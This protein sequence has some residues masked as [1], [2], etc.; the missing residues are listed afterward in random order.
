[1]NA[2]DEAA[3]YAD[4]PAKGEA[5]PPKAYHERRQR[6]KVEKAAEEE[7][8]R[9]AILKRLRW[10]APGGRS[11][12]DLER[13]MG[14]TP[15]SV[16]AVLLQ[17]RADDLAHDRDE[18]W[19]LGPSSAARTPEPPAPAEDFTSKLLRS[20][21]GSP[22]RWWTRM[23]LLSESCC[24]GPLAQRALDQLVADGRLQ[25]VNGGVTLPIKPRTSEQA[26]PAPT[27]VGASAPVGG[28]TSSSLDSGATAERDPS[29][30][31]TASPPAA[32]LR[33]Q[34]V[35]GFVPDPDDA[36]TDGE[37][38]VQPD[39]SETSAAAAHPDPGPSDDPR[40]TG[41]EQDGAHE[42]G[43]LTGPPEVREDP[44][45][46]SS[47]AAGVATG[48]GVETPAAP[49]DR[50]RD[51]VVA[52]VQ[53]EPGLTTNQIAAR[54]NL[55]R[56]QVGHM[57]ERAGLRSERERDPHAAGGRGVTVAR[58]YWAGSSAESGAAAPSRL[59][60]GPA[61]GHPRRDQLVRLVCEH[62]EGVSVR[63]LARETGLAGTLVSSTLQSAAALG[64]IRRTGATLSSRYWPPVLGPSTEADESWGSW[65]RRR[66]DELGLSQR[67]L[68]EAAGVPHGQA[69]VA[70]LE[71]GGRSSSIHIPA[72]ERVLNG[73]VQPHHEPSAPATATGSE[74]E[75]AAQPAAA[76]PGGPDLP[77]CAMQ[78]PAAAGVDDG[79]LGEPASAG[80]RED[81]PEA[82]SAPATGPASQSVLP[83]P[84]VRRSAG[85]AGQDG[86]G[87]GSFG[88]VV[89]REL[90]RQFTELFDRAVAAE[91]RV[92]EL[93][94]QA[95]AAERQVGLLAADLQEVEESLSRLGVPTVGELA[96]RLGWLEGRWGRG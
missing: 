69:V 67:E 45:P 41:P 70:G 19:Y 79:L 89:E 59:A 95:E 35:S 48:G 44:E 20:A 28:D 34:A 46:R 23:Q 63:E 38:A 56:D 2:T 78:E 60:G 75:P 7:A 29:A 57:A 32:G 76:D 36:V 4:I 74:T 15:G 66:R 12:A 88:L 82:G 3:L 73:G 39:R 58:W 80:R 22:S 49:S 26:H 16:V 17:L 11:R 96:W 93:V 42:D 81:G 18:V 13:L 84:E 86:A 47:A 53:A 92:V 55:K 52:L 77:S 1:M 72:L 54:L 31:E 21:E 27:S 6:M 64:L 24:R 30:A 8:R 85:V 40:L 91:S 10:A 9:Q 68:G 87:A 5:P 62:P 94:E 33:D 65:C 51:R 25:A 50:P 83:A 37:P 71:S 90:R 14:W 61:L 43:R